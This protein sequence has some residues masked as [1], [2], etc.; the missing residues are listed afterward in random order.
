MRD[1]VALGYDVY[2]NPAAT[3]RPTILL[4]PT[5][6]IIHSRFWKMQ[7]PYLARHFHVVVYDGPG[8]GNSDRV[9]D[10]ARYSPQSYAADAAAV[11]DA[12]DVERA[13]AVGL[14]RGAW[15]ALELAALRPETLAGLVLIGS[16]LP[17]APAL[18]QREEIIDHFVD[19]A[20]QNPQ[21]QELLAA[22]GFGA[23]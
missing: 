20:P 11:L 15:Y 2:G 4:L 14:S 17:L 5:W 9:T 23:P 18:S 16:A 10:P 6:T 3:D 13:V 19:P 22:H 12:C 8:N 7:V 1:G 21:G